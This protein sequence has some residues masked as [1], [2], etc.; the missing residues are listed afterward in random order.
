MLAAAAFV[1]AALLYSAWIPFQFATPGADA[2]HGYVSE[3]AARD[4]PWSGSLR[5]TD[6]LSGLACLLGTALT[7]RVA[8][9]WPGRLALA[10]FGLFTVADSAFPLDCACTR[11]AYPL[12]HHLHSVTSTLATGAVLASMVL[13][14]RRWRSAPAW[15]ITVASATATIMTI[16]AMATGA[17]IGTTQRVQV[18]LIAAWLLYLAVRLATT[19]AR[20][21]TAPM[22]VV[23]EGSGPPVLLV[24]GVAGAWFHWDAVA[25]DLA[26]DHR[27]IRFDRPP[28]PVPPTLYG[29]AER[30]AG[31]DGDRFTVIA[32]SA[33][34]WH[35]EALARLH[36]SRVAGLVLV[37]PG[38][39]PR[40]RRRTS[41]P[42]RALGRW[43]PAW[44]S[45]WSATALA[46]LLGPPV[47]RLLTGVQDR[48]VYR[49]GPFL[50]ASMGEWLAYRDM[51]ADLEEIR[52]AHPWPGIPVV[53]ITAGRADPCHEALAAGWRA[54]LVR[55]PDAGHQL[56]RMN[57]R[58]IADACRSL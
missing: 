16:A 27:V 26:A 32:H 34:A 24:A 38:C 58:L 15:T 56:P 7:P 17:F 29:E 51:A 48:G 19:G 11:A 47:H 50:A 42:G 14:S 31:F 33:G 53:I 39:E 2:V 4:Q 20:R 18:I 52:R 21:D 25:G 13:L 44:G 35:A 1:A 37:D 28:P 5:L 36:P 41:A 12:S 49:S 6:A 55:V 22:R 9:E 3:L 43:L 54:R 57:P 23:S 30:L 46:R 10:S 45:T 40:P 8:A